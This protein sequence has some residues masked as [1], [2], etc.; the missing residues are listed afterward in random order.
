MSDLAPVRETDDWLAE[1]EG[2]DVVQESKQV[3]IKLMHWHVCRDCNARHLYDM[4][5]IPDE[6]PCPGYSGITMP[7]GIC[8]HC[9]RREKEHR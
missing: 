6:P 1:H 2:H 4:E 3:S 8:V 9:G 5:T 7:D